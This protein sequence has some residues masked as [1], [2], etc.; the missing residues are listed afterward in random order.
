MEELACLV[1]CMKIAF[2][3]LKN[4]VKVVTVTVSIEDCMQTYIPFSL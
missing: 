2:R 3:N 4:L 1:C